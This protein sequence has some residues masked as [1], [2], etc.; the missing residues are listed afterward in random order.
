VTA[1]MSRT[2]KTAPWP[3]RVLYYP[4]W[5]DEYHDHR[6]GECDLPARPRNM[7]DFGSRYRLFYGGRRDVDETRCYWVAS[8][9][10]F[11]THPL[12]RCPCP[13]CKRYAFET[14]PADAQRREARRYCQDGWRDEY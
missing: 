8:Y 12:S 13:L 1:G 3:V 14:R 6:E 11:W 7:K 9:S 2:D 10:Q 4:D 5:L